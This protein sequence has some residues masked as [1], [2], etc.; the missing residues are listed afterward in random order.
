MLLHGWGDCSERLLHVARH[1]EHAGFSGV[2][3]DQRGHG[4]S[5]GRRGDFLAVTDFL[6]D[7]AVVRAGLPGGKASPVALIGFSFGGQI[8]VHAA[9]DGG[10]PGV[11]AV[12]LVGPWFRLRLRASAWQRALAAIASRIVPGLVQETP[13]HPSQLSRDEDWLQEQ[14]TRS[15]TFT[16]RLISARAYTLAVKSGQEALAAAPRVAVPV[17]AAHGLADPVTDPEAT[18]EFMERASSPNK[19]LQLYDGWLHELHN[20]PGRQEFLEDLTLWLRATDRLLR[21]RRG[22]MASA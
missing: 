4:L 2:V 5:G 14:T 20:E 3:Y 17:F 10:M 16:H 21:H 9:T 1:I 18:R 12:G 11:A 13:L 15:Q 7:L 22:N 6:E 8:A 19:T